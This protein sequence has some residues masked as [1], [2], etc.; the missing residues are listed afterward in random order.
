MNETAQPKPLDAL[1][2]AAWPM[3]I[4][5]ADIPANLKAAEGALETIDR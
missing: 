4:V 3:P 1:N 5:W 2:V